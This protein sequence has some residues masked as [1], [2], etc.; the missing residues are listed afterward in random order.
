VVTYNSPGALYN[1]K[2]AEALQMVA[3]GGTAGSPHVI[4]LQEQGLR[5]RKGARPR[6]P[7]YDDHGVPYRLQWRAG[8]PM[9]YRMDVEVIRHPLHRGHKLEWERRMAVYTVVTAAGRSRW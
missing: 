8:V 4:L 6:I 2:T 1:T 9:L 7:V 3:L 5:G